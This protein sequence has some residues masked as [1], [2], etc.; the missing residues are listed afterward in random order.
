MICAASP[1][2]GYMIVHAHGYAKEVHTMPD[3]DQGKA[4]TKLHICG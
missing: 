4:S 3:N 1:V 2:V